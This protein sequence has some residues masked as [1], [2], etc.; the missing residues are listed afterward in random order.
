M[1]QK[2][3]LAMLN[4]MNH[5]CWAKSMPPLWASCPRDVPKPL[6]ILI[7]NRWPPDRASM[8]ELVCTAHGWWPRTGL[9]AEAGLPPALLVAPE[10]RRDFPNQGD[11]R[12]DADTA[13]ETKHERVV[14]RV[15]GRG[16]PRVD[17]VDRLRVQRND[18]PDLA[19]GE[20][21]ER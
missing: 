12:P 8:P 17:D 7:W 1:C 20:H 11:D 6:E 13:A 4:P 2:N 3:F 16:R 18:A 19:G 10:A 5:E 21:S 9:D 15:V 14:I